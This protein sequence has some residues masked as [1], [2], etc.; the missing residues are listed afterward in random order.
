[1]DNA[2]IK[3][4]QPCSHKINITYG[5][6]YQARILAVGCSHMD[7]IYTDKKLL[8]KH[9]TQA[10]EAGAL[11]IFDGDNSDLMQGKGDKRSRKQELRNDLKDAYIDNV[12][13]ST[14]DFL[15]PFAHNIA[16]FGLGNHELA[17]LDRYETN[18]AKRIV[19]KLN[20]STGS[21]I[22]LGGYS[23]YF[24][25]SF[26]H[27][28]GGSRQS[29]TIYYSHSSG[30][31]GMRSK[32]ILSCDVLAGKYQSP[33]IYLTAHNH[34]NYLHF[35][36]YENLTDMGKI[37]YKDKLFLQLPSYK[38]E[39]DQKDRAGWWVMTNK[40]PRIIGGWWIDL[41]LEDKRIKFNATMAR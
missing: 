29:I 20:L 27:V 11:I 19:E 24:K 9:L 30:S 40:N 25:L 15:T 38:A 17:I 39:W 12:V 16:I 41:Y 10:K 13:D 22:Q 3:Q 23:G 7:S 1:M 26:T 14:V 32:G 36:G 8:L 34:D 6:G 5:P 28:S 37:T 18:V 21:N 31:M 4:I 35:F 2:C 33:D